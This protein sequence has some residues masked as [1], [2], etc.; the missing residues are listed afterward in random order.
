MLKLIAKILGNKSTRDI[1]RLMPLVEKAK[2]DWEQ[3]KS[4]TNDE[5]R[6]ETVKIQDTINSELKGIDDNLADLHKKISENP[7]L[8]INEKEN[9]FAQIDKIELDRDKELEKVLLKVLPRT[10]AIVRETARR[11]KDNEYLEVTAQDFDRKFAGTHPNV[12][13]DGDT[14]RWYNQWMAAGNMITW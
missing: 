11:F 2:E 1:K 6:N 8:D 5:L 4:L 12:K 3:L 10:F 13:I 9:I 14:A 7:Q